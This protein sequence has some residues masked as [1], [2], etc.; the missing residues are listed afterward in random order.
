M[1]LVLHYKQGRIRDETHHPVWL[2]VA[3]KGY[4]S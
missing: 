4:V 3:N 2:E 1:E